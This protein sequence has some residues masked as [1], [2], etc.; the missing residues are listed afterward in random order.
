MPGHQIINWFFILTQIGAE[1]HLFKRI[2]LL[3]MLFST[4][5]SQALAL[6]LDEKIGQML[7]IGFDGKTIDANSKIVKIIEESNIG[8]VILF[9]YN[10]QTKQFDKNIESPEQVKLLNKQL[11]NYTSN[12]NITNHRENLPLLISVDYEG[13]KIN[14]LSEAYGFPATISAKNIGNMPR[15]E[16]NNIAK[17]MAQTLKSA[18]FNL[19]FA[20]VLDVN[21]NP[22]NPVIGKKERSFSSNPEEVAAYAKIFSEQFLNH[23]VQCAYKHFPG[24]G[25]STKDSHLGF[26][27]VTDTWQ[28]L[29]LIPYEKMIAE[30]KH[31][32]IIMSAHIVN[33]KL[34]AEGFP[35][36]LSYEILTNTLRKKLKFDGVII[37]DDM[38]MKAITDNYGTDSAVTLA[39]NAGADM[40]VFGNQLTPS[41]VDPKEIIAI[42]KQKI[43][44][45]EIN[46]ERI[47]DAYRHITNLKNNLKTP[48]LRVIE[49]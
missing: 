44:S 19:D 9:D 37:T 46:E 41:Y 18:G 35:A 33:K 30:P 49:L 34:D 28:D 36:T 39:I 45:G 11:Q 3:I 7:I 14:R 4:I 16:A 21:I 42:I 17:N 6:T 40:L 43:A 23:G 47:N 32:G 5:S 27:D 1:M 22:E 8:G 15:D 20:P 31:C 10:N 48:S 13:G 26:V 2:L 38:Q 24:H 12:A 25:S 29:E